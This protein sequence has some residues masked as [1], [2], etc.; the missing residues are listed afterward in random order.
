[1]I[2]FVLVVPDPELPEDRYLTKAVSWP[3]LPRVGEMVYLPGCIGRDVEQVRHN[4]S[5]D[6][7]TRLNIEVV[8]GV[9]EEEFTALHEAFGW[10]K[11]DFD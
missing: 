4:F 11:N 6:S 2:N 9:V 10:E 5:E 1:M 8:V 7:L 3:V